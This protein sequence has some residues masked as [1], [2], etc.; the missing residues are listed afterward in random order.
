M[1]H[2]I[3]AQ[4][5]SRQRPAAL[6][7][8]VALGGGALLLAVLFSVLSFF[9][10][11]LEF[12]GRLRFDSVLP[13]SSAGWLNNLLFDWFLPLGMSLFAIQFGSGL[14]A[15]DEENGALALLLAGPL[16]RRRLLLERLAA[17]LVG[18]AALAILVFGLLAL[19][20]AAFLAGLSYGVLAAACANLGLLAFFFG[21]LA[22][23]FGCHSGRAH[24]SRDLAIA[25][26]ALFFLAN[27]LPGFIS[28]ASAL[29][30]ISPFHYYAGADPLI[31][32]VDL[33]DALILAGS[34]FLLGL[35]A[36]LRF[37][38]RDLGI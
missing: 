5:L 7:W 21:A 4:T 33:A 35:A 19:W 37:D 17:L 14:T 29:R 12:L 23:F 28:G 10:A 36:L 32:G 15:V 24:L 25:L 1:P 26:M 8:M 27:L 31:N 30:P 11:A 9:P 18:C 16:S 20:N 6:R 13:N 22:A 3:F 2:S 38:R 34:A